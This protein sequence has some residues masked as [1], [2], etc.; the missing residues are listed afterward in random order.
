MYS[1]NN[2]TRTRRCTQSTTLQEQKD[3]HNQ[4][5]NKK[6]YTINNT[7]RTRRCTKTTLQEQ[8][9]VLK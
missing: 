3:I 1:N 8:E 4:Q 7:T 2:T 5:Q 6:M 9:D